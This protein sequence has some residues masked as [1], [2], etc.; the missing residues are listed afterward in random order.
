MNVLYDLHNDN[1][2]IIITV[3][4][5]YVLLNGFTLIILPKDFWISER[6]LIRFFGIQLLIILII[7]V[8]ATCIMVKRHY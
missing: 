2:I 5:I 6:K 3:I 7:A 8:F 1:E 4:L